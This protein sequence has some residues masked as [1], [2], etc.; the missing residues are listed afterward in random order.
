MEDVVLSNCYT[1]LVAGIASKYP[2]WEGAKQFK[3]TPA[4]LRRMYQDY[5]WSGRKIKEELAKQFR[6][7][8]DGYDEM[9]VAKDISVWTL[10]P[11]HLLPC[12]FSVYIGYLPTGKVLGLSKF[13]R[14]AEILAKRP[15]I[16]EQFSTELADLL[17]DNLH[18]KGVAV[19]VV[20]VHGC[21]TSRGVRQNSNI[22]TSVLRGCFLK[23][24]STRDEFFAI[25]RS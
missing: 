3:G 21:I 18:P 11:H 8:E 17:A 14:I 16:Q 9:L 10:C 2:N 7:F 1:E 5:C 24:G 19:Y 22:V 4:R 20:G 15:V 23:E 6:V 25:C 12:H 13:A